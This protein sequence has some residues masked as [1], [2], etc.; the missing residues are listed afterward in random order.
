M[1]SH[2]VVKILFET[3]EAKKESTLWNESSVLLYW[4]SYI[5]QVE[6]TVHVYWET[7]SQYKQATITK[8]YKKQ[9]IYKSLYND[10]STTNFIL[11]FSENLKL[12]VQNVQ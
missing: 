4:S 2:K 9:H 3:K 6:Y 5:L 1:K 7:D 10:S 8:R 11:Q 12:S